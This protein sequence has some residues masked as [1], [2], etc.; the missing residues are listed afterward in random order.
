[1]KPTFFFRVVAIC[2][3]L[4]SPGSHP[5]KRRTTTDIPAG[6]GCGLWLAI[7]AG[8]PSGAEARQFADGSWRTVNLPH[9]WSIEGVPD[10][11]NPPLPEADSSLRGQAGIARRL[12]R[13]KS[14]KASG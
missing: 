4:A 11:D 1:M 2:A 9:D 5:D 7:P 6:A 13:P 14:G 10:K 3:A 12:P 8:D